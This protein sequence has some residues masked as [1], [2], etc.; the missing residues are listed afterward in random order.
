VEQYSEGLDGGWCLAWPI[1][2]TARALSTAA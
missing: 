2:P 1:T